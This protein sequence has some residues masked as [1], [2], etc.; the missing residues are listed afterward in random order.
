MVLQDGAVGTDD[1]H[2][3]PIKPKAGHEANSGR[4]ARRG[5]QIHIT[6]GDFHARPAADPPSRT[7]LGHGGTGQTA[8]RL[9]VVGSYGPRHPATDDVSFPSSHETLPRA[10]HILGHRTHLN[11]LRRPEITQWLLSACDGI[12]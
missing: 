7:A 5:R 4:T 3:R 8:R 1:A 9:Q 2:H 10:K 6:A 11:E 12:D